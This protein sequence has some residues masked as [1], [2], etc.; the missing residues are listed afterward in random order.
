MPH[1]M[2]ATLR[3]RGTEPEERGLADTRRVER[4]LK[5]VPLPR[6]R[7]EAHLGQRRRALLEDVL[8]PL[9]VGRERRV[10]DGR[11]DRGP[12]LQAVAGRRVAL[13]P[14]R[15]TRLDETGAPQHGEV[16]RDARL[17]GAENP[18]DLPHLQLLAGEKT[19]RPQAERVGEGGQGGGGV[20][21]RETI[22][23]DHAHVILKEREENKENSLR[24]RRGATLQAVAG[25]AARK[26]AARDSA[27][28]VRSHVN[29]GRRRPK[30]P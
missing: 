2:S 3:P 11:G 24:K 1:P 21:H 25:T 8:Q 12:E 5:A 26:A 23:H 9:V 19:D 18:L 7:V 29:S 13:G 10:G 30:W 27:L 14:V 6:D 16:V 22:S 20:Q 15:P 4:A 28:S 17:S